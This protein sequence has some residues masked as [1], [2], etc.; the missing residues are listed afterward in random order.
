M[1]LACVTLTYKT[2][3]YRDGAVRINIYTKS[4]AKILNVC[5]ILLINFKYVE[6][7]MQQKN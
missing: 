4:N 2:S 6:I 5:G 7:D 3:Q 1:S